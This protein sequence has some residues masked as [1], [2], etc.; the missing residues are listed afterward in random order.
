MLT[1]VVNGQ[2]LSRAE[3]YLSLYIVG[4]LQHFQINIVDFLQQYQTLPI[5]VM[6]YCNILL[7][8]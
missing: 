2:A 1:N 3:I 6:E 7:N 8:F 5:F 4:L